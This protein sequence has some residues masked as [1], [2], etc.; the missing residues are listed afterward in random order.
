MGR[1]GKPDRPV[2]LEALQAM[3]SVAV[4]PDFKGEHEMHPATYRGPLLWTVLD[5]AGAIDADKHRDHVRE[6]VT[7][8]GSDGYTAIIAAAEIDPAFERKQVILAYESDGQ[9]LGSD[10]L[11]VIV[12]VDKRGGRSVHDVVRVTVAP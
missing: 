6:T 5:R 10:H 4:V 2:T 3:P 7:I 1:Q 9:G 11:R 12:P 8:A